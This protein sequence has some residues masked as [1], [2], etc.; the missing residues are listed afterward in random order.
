M[1]FVPWWVAAG[2]VA[3]LVAGFKAA[4]GID[5]NVSRAVLTKSIEMTIGLQAIGS[6]L[7]FVGA[8]FAR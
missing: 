2:G 8:V 4:S 3:V 6:I 1:E 5:E 7:L